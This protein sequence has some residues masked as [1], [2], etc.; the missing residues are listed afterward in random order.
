M[1]FKNL[2]KWRHKLNVCIR[3][4]YCYEHCHLFKVSGWETDSTR[5]K[6]I[7]LHNMMEGNLE[8]DDFIAEKMFE[9]FMCKRCDNSC[10]AKV[11]IT[12]LLTDARLDFIAAGYDPQGTTSAVNHDLCS[13]CGVCIA[14]CKH[15]AKSLDKEEKK[16]KVDKSKCQSCGVC[17]AAC[18][19]GAAY[20]KDGY[21]VTKH[22]MLEKIDTFLIGG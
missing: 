6:L 1:E 16:V 15:E 18:P 9:C 2:E 10:S 4:G 8:P 11:E 19:S 12:D 22:E 17:V 5:G 14:V 21:E 20:L 13:R 7:M 3:C